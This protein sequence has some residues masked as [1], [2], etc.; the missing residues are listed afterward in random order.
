M[1][2][3]SPQFH[4]LEASGESPM[5]SMLTTTYEN[6]YFQRRVWCGQVQAITRIPLGSGGLALRLLGA[7]GKQLA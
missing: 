2:G 7:L 3:A 6:A 4:V 5:N 1:N